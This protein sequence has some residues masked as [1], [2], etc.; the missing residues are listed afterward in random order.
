[1][2]H[3]SRSPYRRAGRALV[4]LL[5]ALWLLSVAGAAAVQLLQTGQAASASLSYVDETRSALRQAAETVQRT[6]CA[7]HADSWSRG[8]TAGAW[9]SSGGVG[10]VT[11]TLQ[12]WFETPL[13]LG[14]TPLPLE[15]RFAGWCP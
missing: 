7:A 6:P 13:P 3:T 11:G 9:A 5:V 15:A 12:A 10:A 14:A 4:E 2:P 1:M 8:R